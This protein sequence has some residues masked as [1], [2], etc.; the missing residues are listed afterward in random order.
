MIQQ[1]LQKMQLPGMPAQPQSIGAALGSGPKMV[2]QQMM[3]GGQMPAMPMQPPIMSPHG[4]RPGVGI[5]GMIAG[6][7]PMKRAPMGQAR[8]IGLPPRTRQEAQLNPSVT[9]MTTNFGGGY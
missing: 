7:Q 2:P 1:M 4:L 5:G 6:P 8:P 9:Q 3:P